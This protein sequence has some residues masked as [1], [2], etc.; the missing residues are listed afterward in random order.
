MLSNTRAITCEALLT[1]AFYIRERA[2]FY[3]IAREGS[4]NTFAVQCARKLLDYF[5]LQN[6]EI[7]VESWRRKFDDLKQS[8]PQRP[9]TTGG[10][11]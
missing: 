5:L 7:K 3:A 11:R 1:E 4:P 6:P 2:L 9:E 10:K 8:L